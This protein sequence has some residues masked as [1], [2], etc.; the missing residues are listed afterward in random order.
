MKAVRALRFQILSGLLARLVS[1]LINIGAKS[2]QGA[3]LNQT[4]LAGKNGYIF[5]IACLENGFKRFEHD[6]IGIGK[7]HINIFGE[8]GC[9]NELHI[10]RGIHRQGGQ[11]DI[12]GGGQSPDP[13][14][15]FHRLGF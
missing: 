4:R 7:E 2:S 10:G 14:H 3:S 8:Q 15:G 1:P 13:V 5:L 9:G 6:I 11:P 12:I